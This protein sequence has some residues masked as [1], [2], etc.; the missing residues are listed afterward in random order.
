MTLPAPGN[1]SV[2]TQR[3]EGVKENKL[4]AAHFRTLIDSAEV[5]ATNEFGA[6]VFRT[7]DGAIL[8]LFRPCRWFSTAL[9]CSYA[10][11]FILAARELKSRGVPTLEPEALYWM[12][13]RNQHAVLYRPLAGQTLRR[14]LDG[15]GEIE[16]L[17]SNLASFCASLHG[18]GVY[19]RGMHLNNVVVG[20]DGE[21]GLIDLS[22]A[23]FSSRALG[24]RKRVRNFKPFVRLEPDRQTMTAYGS[25]RFIERYLQAAGLSDASNRILLDGL[26]RLDR[27]YHDAIPMEVGGAT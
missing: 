1:H 14:L 16:L 22:S 26:Q 6:S 23:T 25:Q 18:K 2:E 19:F 24:L 7:S 21:Y 8:K 4:S 27:I 12:K 5:L 17:M 9:H 20:V 10:K 13:A 11:R 15:E 3:I